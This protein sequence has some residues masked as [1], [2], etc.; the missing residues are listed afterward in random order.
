M[1]K[2]SEPKNEAQVSEMCKNARTPFFFW[3][4]GYARAQWEWNE[5]IDILRELAESAKSFVRAWNRGELTPIES[6]ELEAKLKSW[7]KL[8]EGDD[9]E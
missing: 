9:E 2:S 1:A 8:K 3:K 6:R 5:E 7:R 4:K